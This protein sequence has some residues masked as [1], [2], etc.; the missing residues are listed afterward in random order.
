MKTCKVAIIGCGSI[1]LELAKERSRK[2]DVVFAT[3]PS[4]ENLHEISKF[5]QKSL[6]FKEHDE[7]DLIQIISQNEILVV[8]GV[9]DSL[10]HF[11]TNHLELSQTIRRL[12]LDMNAPR[13]LIYLSSIRVYGDHKGM[14]VDEMSELLARSDAARAMIDAER[15]YLSLD[16][17]GWDVCVL[18]LGEVYGIG[19]DTLHKLQHLDHKMPGDGEQFTNMIHIEDCVSAIQYAMVHDLPGIYNLVDDDHQTRKEFYDTVAKKHHLPI[20][21]WDKEHP[22]LY[23]G[24][25]RISN[26]KI[27]KTGLKLIHHL[28]VID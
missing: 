23:A 17:I 28:R 8:T 12:A 26:H 10:E 9:N 11:E 19:K 16:E 27:K 18:R 2:G 7:E 14:W 4:S 25:K 24:N 3:C 21:S 6:V 1:G 20:V 13:K 15:N 22:I 5:V